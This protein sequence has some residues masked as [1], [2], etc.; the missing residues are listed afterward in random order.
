M[1]VLF[2]TP[3]NSVIASDADTSANCRLMARDTESASGSRRSSSFRVADELRSMA[4]KILLS[5]N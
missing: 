5:A 3:S 4:G 2:I 1:R